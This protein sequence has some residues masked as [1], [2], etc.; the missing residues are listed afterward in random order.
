VVLGNWGLQV[1][2]RR[3]VVCFYPQQAK[4]DAITHQQILASLD[5]ALARGDKAMPEA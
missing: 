4:R 2:P 1:K 3:Y 5:H